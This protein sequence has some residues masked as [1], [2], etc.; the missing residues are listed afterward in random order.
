MGEGPQEV[1][2]RPQPQGPASHRRPNLG[3]GLDWSPVFQ[4]DLNDPD[5]SVPGR[6]VEGR[7]LVLQG[8][9]TKVSMGGAQRGQQTE[10]GQS[11][12]GA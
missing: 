4:Q 10:C 2:E 9:E 12:G 3:L 1:T 7:Q 8:Q 11:M 6:T 5:V